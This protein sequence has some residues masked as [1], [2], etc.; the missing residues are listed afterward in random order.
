[1]TGIWS[2]AGGSERAKATP[3]RRALIVAHGQ[4]SDPDP[5][6]AALARLAERV[7]AELPAAWQV[8]AATLAAP[9]ALEAALARAGSGSAPLLI[10]P[11]FIADGWFTQVNLPARLRAAGMVIVQSGAGLGDDPTRNDRPAGAPANGDGIV[12]GEGGVTLPC[13]GGRDLGAAAAAAVLRAPEGHDGTSVAGR[14]VPKGPAADGQKRIAAAADGPEPAQPAAAGL[15][16]AAASR[17]NHGMRDVQILPPFGLDPGILPLALQGLRAAL[18]DHGLRAAEMGLIV[19][20]HGS[21]KSPAP[22]AVARR[23]ARAIIAELPFAEMRTAFIDQAPRIADFAGGLPAP[24]LCLPLFAA[25]G[26][27]VEDDL[28][29]ALAEAG[30]SGHILAPL[31]LAEGAPGLVAAALLAAS[32]REYLGL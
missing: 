27:H 32:G 4:P 18:A 20:A 23:L 1:M 31:G 7:A 25:A 5:A 6:E 15:D 9:G 13:G 24:A 11:M 3:A 8:E 17:A 16:D 12:R 29:A 30:F 21:F 10:Y 19:A 26:G 14:A 2:E 22:A 28:P